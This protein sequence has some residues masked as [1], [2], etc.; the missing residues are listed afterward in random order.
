[1]ARLLFGGRHTGTTT[2][3]Q[4]STRDL[5]RHREREEQ[6]IG[7]PPRVAPSA[8]SEKRKVASMRMVAHKQAK[9]NR[10]GR[11]W[12][13]QQDQA[14]RKA[15][16]WLND[17]SEQ[18]IFRIAGFAG[19]GKTDVAKEIGQKANG[20]RFCA[21][22]GK[23]A[24]VLRQRGCESTLT[25]HSL[26]YKP[27]KDKKTGDTRFVLKARSELDDVRLIVVDE[28]SMVADGLA[29]DL[30]SFGIPILAVYDLAQLPPVDGVG[31]FRR[32]NPD[33]NLTEIHR[34]ALESPIIRLA[35]QVRR[36]QPLPLKHRDGDAVRIVMDGF[37]VDISKYD[38]MLCGTNNYRCRANDGIRFRRGFGNAYPTPQ[39]S[40]I[41]V[42]LRNDYRIDPPVF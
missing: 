12:S 15:G 8:G 32:G 17:P 6:Q 31:Y 22:T 19:T 34:Q 24:H 38:V 10:R 37:D 7:N 23:A 4:V 16:A 3:R 36:G 29:R 13:P 28:A 14:L 42:C 11:S 39:A 5:I 20:A 35:D 21:F 30:L 41:V 33:V 25:I 2:S 27:I 9:G 40:E 1:M 26:I 18:Q